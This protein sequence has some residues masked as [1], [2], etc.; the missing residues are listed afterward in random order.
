MNQS[1]REAKAMLKGHLAGKLG[2][3]PLEV[4]GY[5]PGTPELLAWCKG[6]ARGRIMLAARCINGL[7][8]RQLRTRTKHPRFQDLINHYH[9]CLE[10]LTRCPVP[11]LRLEELYPTLFAM[12]GLPAGLENMESR[13]ES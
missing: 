4:C 2:R 8:A 12:Y 6:Y 7:Y 10:D 3:C 13:P 11:L 9:K 1:Q 5:E